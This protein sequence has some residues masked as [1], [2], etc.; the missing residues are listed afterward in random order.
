MSDIARTKVLEILEHNWTSLHNPDYTDEELGDALD[1]CIASL[2]TDEAYQL[3]Y[4]LTTKNDLGVDCISRKAVERII[5]KWLS[6]SD[7]E[8]KEH[9]YSMTEKIHNL[10]SVT[11]QEPKTGHWIRVTDKAGHLVWECDK[12]GWQQRYNTNFCPDCGCAM[13]EPQER[14]DKE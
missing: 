7:Y 13:I 4:E 14:S 8:L 5:N 1:F 11:P 12:C 9:I 10:A 3:E 6:H 2:E